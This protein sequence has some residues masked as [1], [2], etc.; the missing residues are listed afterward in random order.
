MLSRFASTALKSQTFYNA[1]YFSEVLKSVPGNKA[2]VIEETVAGRYAGVLFRIAS[3]NEILHLVAE[4][5]ERLNEVAKQSVAVRNFLANSSSKRSEQLAVFQT[6]YPSLNEITCQFLDVLI[7]NKRTYALEKIT[8]TYA[9]YVKMLNKEESVRVVSATELNEDQRSRLL[10][11]L[12]VQYEGVTFTMKY[13]VNPAI[14]GGLQMYT[15]NRFLDCSLVSRVNFV[16][17]ELSK[18]YA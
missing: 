14:M 13:D 8:A 5:M 18:M 10:D 11:A 17:T 1:R 4:D 15:G 3:K 7:D 6:V 9:R 2:P 16:R 12:N